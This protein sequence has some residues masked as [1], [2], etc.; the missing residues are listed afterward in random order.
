MVADHN[1]QEAA[2]PLSSAPAI[3]KFLNAV[4]T[5]S[6]PTCDAWSDDAMLDA[7]VPNW[8]LHASGA[9]A[10]RATSTNGRCGST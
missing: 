6:I 7:T 3:D 10:I 8:R 4:Q 2:M 1:H 9:D 5:A